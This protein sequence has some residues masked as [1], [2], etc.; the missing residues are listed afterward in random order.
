MPSFNQIW[1]A[2]LCMAVVTYSTRV[3][4]FIL[5]RMQKQTSQTDKNSPVLATL[6]PSLLAA[7]TVVTVI[8]GVQKTIQL[9]TI[10]QLSYILGVLTTLLALKFTRNA[11]FAVLAGVAIFALVSYCGSL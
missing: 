3:L 8:P 9:G 2:V 6:G 1:L 7:I 10:A 5:K 11:G 4:P